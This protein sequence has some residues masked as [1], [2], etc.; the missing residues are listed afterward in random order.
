M[1]EKSNKRSIYSEITYGMLK[2]KKDDE[3]SAFHKMKETKYNFSS[4]S[5][6]HYIV[7]N[8]N[9]SEEERELLGHFLASFPHAGN[10]DWPNTFAKIDV[11]KLPKK[12]LHLAANAYDDYGNTVLGVAAEYG[13]Q[14]E[15]VQRLIDMGA[16]LNAPDHN[17]NKLP[18]HWAIH[19]KL[20]YNNKTSYEAIKVVKCLLDNG[21]KVDITCYRNSNPLAYAKSGGFIAAAN[22][23][24][25]HQKTIRSLFQL[26]FF[27]LRNMIEEE[28]ITPDEIANVIQKDLVIPELAK[29]I[30]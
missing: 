9:L 7:T 27:K 30:K 1:L 20:S 8:Q 26:C 11:E 15:A 21:A 5:C 13:K 3:E 18:L 23:I 28:I 29:L 12:L 6:K 24:E 16:R 25:Q 19:N 4:G 17:M 22:L 2:K 14:V 10:N